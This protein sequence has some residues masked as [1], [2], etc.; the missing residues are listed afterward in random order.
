MSAIKL[1]K[2]EVMNPVA[3]FNSELNFDIQFEC[4][5][6][7]QDGT[8]LMILHKYTRHNRGDTHYYVLAL[9]TH[10]PPCRF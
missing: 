4:F 7:L 10:L 5:E 3:P 1:E 6:A 8:K 9:L 2:V